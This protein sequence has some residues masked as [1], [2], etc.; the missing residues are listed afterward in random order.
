[1]VT[2]AATPKPR[3]SGAATLLLAALVA[4]FAL[5]GLSGYLVRAV[6]VP[7]ANVDR[8]TGAVRSTAVCPIATHA[9]VWYTAGTWACVSDGSL[10][11]PIVAHQP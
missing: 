7:V 11:E 5:G 10:P 9:V 8:Q 6:V 2:N 4:T 1:M 3:F